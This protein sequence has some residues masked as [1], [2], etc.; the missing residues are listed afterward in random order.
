MDRIFSA[1]LDVGVIAQIRALAKRLGTSQK[2]VIARSVAVF[3]ASLEG[4]SFDPFEATKGAWQRTEQPE[5]TIAASREAFNRS[6]TRHQ[7]DKTK[8]ER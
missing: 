3:G 7:D 1:R 8:D 2:D 5:K 6:M 4:P